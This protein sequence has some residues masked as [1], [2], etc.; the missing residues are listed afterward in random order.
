MHY[1]SQILNSL[2][3]AH[4]TMYAQ[5]VYSQAPY[6]DSFYGLRN[7]LEAFNAKV[8]PIRLEEGD[9]EHLCYPIIL[10]YEGRHIVL[11][12]APKEMTVLH[13][14]IGQAILGVDTTD[15]HEPELLYHRLQTAV[16]YGLPWVAR[17]A[18]L[19]LIVLL[20]L[21]VGRGDVIANDV[22]SKVVMAVL[23]LL[24]LVGIY[25]CHRIITDECSGSC[26]AVVNSAGGKLLGIYSLGVVGMTYFVSYLL[27]VLLFPALY[28]WLLPCSVLAVLFPCWSIYYQAFVVKS[29]CKN[30]L[31]VQFCLFLTATACVVGSL[32]VQ[33][34]RISL[35]SFP[36]VVL[37]MCVGISVFYWC[38]WVVALFKGQTQKEK[39]SNMGLFLKNPTIR[40]EILD[41][42]KQVET[43][44]S[45]SIVWQ[46]NEEFEQEVTLVLGVY[47]KYCRALFLQLNKLRVEGKLN[48][49]R[50]QF[51]LMQEYGGNGVIG[52]IVAETL[53]KGNSEIWEAL[54][55]WYHSGNTK[56]YEKN[57][58]NTPNTTQV[59]ERLN[60]Q[61][62]WLDKNNIHS[63]PYLIYNGKHLEGG[64]NLI[65]FL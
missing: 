17:V 61:S 40:K 22:V 13:Q 46:Q 14:S 8:T 20:Y 21:G 51:V 42:A 38:D 63:T 52:A 18:M 32:F 16:L 41:N 50:I 9:I 1:I 10:I 62:E 45:G 36:P 59:N 35:W 3:I 56:K 25:F 55:R 34:N 26:H 5:Q 15:A 57:Y 54:N 23:V 47:C 60:E 31:W 2:D 43:Q 11:K 27:V 64:I 28:A 49:T 33:S 53:D 65:E 12:E 37:G 58:Q 39:N 24:Q 29:W 6:A 4:T 48:S 7:I 30:C 19:A 44:D